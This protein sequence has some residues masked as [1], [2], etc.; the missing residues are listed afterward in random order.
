MATAGARR[1][2]G[3]VGAPRWSDG[4]WLVLA[5]AGLLALSAATVLLAGARW[6][7]P[8]VL[9]VVVGVVF[10]LTGQLLLRQPRARRTGAYLL[11]VG[12]LWPTGAW[13]LGPGAGPFLSWTLPGVAWGLL[14]VAMLS[15]PAELPLDRT[16]HGYVVLLAVVLGPVNLAQALVSEPEWNGFP[17]DAWWPTVTDS[18][19]WFDALLI[20][21]GIGCL[22]VAAGA[23]V[24]FARRLRLASGV[25]RLALLPALAGVAAGA[26]IAAVTTG[27]QSLVAS[28]RTWAAMVVLQGVVV[29]GLPVSVLL[30]ALRTR[31]AAARVA[32]TVGRLTRPTTPESVRAA[33]RTLLHDPSAEV[34]FWSPERAGHLDGDGSPAAVP[35]DGD[36]LVVDVPAGSG[37]PLAL[38]V[39]DP[40]LAHHAGLVDSTVAA[41]GLA[42]ENARLQAQLRAQLDEVRASRARILEAQMSERRRLGRNLHDGAQQNL[43]ALSMR[44]EAARTRTADETTQHQLTEI[45]AQLRAALAEIRDLAR[46]LH[47]AVLSSAGLGAAVAEMVD[48][49]PAPVLVDLPAERLDPLVESAAYFVISEA[50]ANADKH[51]DAGTIVIRGA[52]ADGDFVLSISDD[53]HGGA[54]VGGTGL[55]GLADRVSALGGTLAVVSPSG[56]GTRVDVR[57]PCP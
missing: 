50:L 40:R 17:A 51:A 27:G 39:I 29:L 24:L 54:D 42:L 15:Y 48:R 1:R 34:L 4:P 37:E 6:P 7:A 30:T 12:V 25:D 16:T 19:P 52:H 3:A 26:A 56:G 2:S 14:A 33:V 5:W 53:G 20:G 21:Y 45:K 11:P 44:L 8:T 35:A 10:T 13:G 22:L 36:R 43:L 9:A 38:L 46:G 57:I 23:V 28:E 47:P 55:R 31:L 41:I 32:E 49:R 18:R